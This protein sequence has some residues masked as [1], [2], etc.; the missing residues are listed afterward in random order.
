[1]RVR[2]LRDVSVRHRAGE[3]VEISDPV[4]L[5][6]LFSARSAEALGAE[7]PRTP[8]AETVIETAAAPARR[9]AAAPA[10]KTAAKTA[11]KK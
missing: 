1:M 9:T 11:R 3:I 6:N 5:N 10:R 4:V 7:A 2:L 8:E